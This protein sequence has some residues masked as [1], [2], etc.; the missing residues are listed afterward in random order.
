MKQKDLNL[1]S[2][3][4]GGAHGHDFPRY[5]ELNIIGVTG[6]VVIMV[7]HG[8]LAALTFGLSGLHLQPDRH[9]GDEPAWRGCSKR[10]RFIGVVFVMAAMAGCGL[11]GF[12]NF[13]V[14]PTVFFGAWTQPTLRLRDGAGRVGRAGH[15]RDLHAARRHAACILEMSRTSPGRGGRSRNAVLDGT[16]YWCSRPH[17]PAPAHVDIGQAGDGAQHVNR[18]D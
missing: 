1:L 17:S 12:L 5:R 16:A 7:A 2:V 11:P 15:R 6:A 4:P 14:K 10:L 3:T 13:V 8:F 18:A 9:A